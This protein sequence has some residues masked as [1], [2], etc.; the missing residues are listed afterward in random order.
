MRIEFVLWPPLIA[1][2]ELGHEYRRQG[3]T[4]IAFA[5]RMREVGKKILE[6]HRVATGTA[7]SDEFKASNEKNIVGCFKQG[8][9][10]QIEQRL[11]ETADVV[12]TVTKAIQI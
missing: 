6:A 12:E 1:L 7:V 3:E 11:T 4:A 8:L 9:R 5:N 2:V 10:P